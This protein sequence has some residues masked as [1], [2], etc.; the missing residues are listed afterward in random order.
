MRDKD[1]VKAKFLKYAE[2]FHLTKFRKFNE[3]KHN[4]IR[5]TSLKEYG[6]LQEM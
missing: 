5:N 6:H 4:D 1:A 3:T 2:Q